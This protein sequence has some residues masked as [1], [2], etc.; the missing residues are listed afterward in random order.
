MFKK[1]YAIALAATAASAVKINA[2]HIEGAL[3]G[4]HPNSEELAQGIWFN[5]TDAMRE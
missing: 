3:L 2:D 4:D 1:L 5:P